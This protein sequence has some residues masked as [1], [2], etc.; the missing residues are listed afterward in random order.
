MAKFKIALL[1]GDGIGIDVVEQGVRV[2]NQIGKKYEHEFAYKKALVG[3]AAID[4]FGNPFPQETLKTCRESDAIL[5]GAVGDYRDDDPHAKVRPVQGLLRMRKELGLFAN[6]RP[7]KVFDALVNCSTLKPEVIKGVSIAILRELT[8]GIYFG[9]PK[10]RKDKGQTAFDTCVYKKSEVERIAKLAFEIARK[11]SKHVTS[12]EKSNVLESSKLWKETVLEVGKR[13]KDVELDHYYVDIASLQ[14]VRKPQRFDVIVTT[15]M[16]GDIL[17]DC[18]AVLA[19]SMGMMP[20]ASFSEGKVHLYE[21]IHGSAPKYKGQNKVNPTATILS[22]AM[23]L[24]YSFNL[25]KEAKTIEKVVEKTLASGFRTYDIM[26]KGCKELGT[27]ELT[28]KIIKNL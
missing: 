15:N 13:Y 8:G 18:S 3:G 25:E 10:G 22:V 14:L 7:V 4:V 11:R 26:E 17:S 19:G 9:E 20:S 16:F 27:K 12:V 23:M 2:L 28:D 21:P 6:L 1:P 24:R 5:F